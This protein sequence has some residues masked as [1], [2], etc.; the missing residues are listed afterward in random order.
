MAITAAIGMMVH[1]G[2]N[3]QSSFYV[4]WLNQSGISGTLIGTLFSLSSITAGI[5]PLLAAPLARRIRPYWL[6]WW[7]V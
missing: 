5:G 4:I 6:L 7:V 1:L 3:I 2:N